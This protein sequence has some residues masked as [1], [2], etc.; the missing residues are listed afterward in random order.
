MFRLLRYFSIAS[1]VSLVLA[2]AVLGAVYRQIATRHLLE[3]GESNNVAL[4]QTLA[5]SFWPQLHSFADST[6][7]L[8]V[9]ALRRHPDIAGLRLGVV[10]Q[11]RDTNMIKVK[12]YNLD[13]RTLFSTETKQVGEY[14]SRNAGFLSARQGQPASEL[15]HRDQFSAFEQVIENRDVLSSYVALRRA[16]DAPIEGVVEVYSD[17]TDLLGGIER[18]QRLVTASVVVVLT[19]LYAILFFIVRHADRVIKGQYEQQRRSEHALRDA[20]EHLEHR[21]QERTT[22]LEVINH[23]L[24]IEVEERKRTEQRIEFMAYHDALTGLPNRELLLDRIK[25]SLTWA[26][27]RGV[28]LAV[29]FID[30]D[31]FK[32][33][34]DS[35]GHHIGDQVLQ[36]IAQRL[37]LCLREGDTIARVGGDEFIVSL[38]DI[39]SDLDLFQIAQKLLDAIVLPIEVA[40][41][42]LHLTAS[43]GIAMYPEHGRDVVTLMRNADSAMYSAK[44][45]GRNR[46]QMF[47]EHMNLRVQQRVMMESAMR[48]AIESNAFE[49]YYQPIVALDSGAIVGAEALLRWPNPHGAWISPVEFIPVAEESGLI[50]PLG[51]WV[52]NEACSQLHR[53]RERGLRDFTLA[54]NLSPCQFAS[55]G[56]AAKV[57][58]E[59]ERAE[60]DPAWLHLEITESL[61][62]SQSEVILANF[63][64]FERLGIKFSL[65]D[66]GTGY[67]SLGYL[68]RFPLHLLKIDRSFVQGL[69]DDSDNAAIVT[70]V[71]AM[72]KSLGMEV[73][74]EGIETDAQRMFLKRL[75]CSHGQGFLFS[76]P[77]PAD[78]FAALIFDPLEI[79]AAA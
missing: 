47:A 77:V 28:Q 42:T 23:S 69:P 45:L 20:Q 68:K 67:S 15:T 29:A 63:D 21:V 17:V 19:L 46:H 64:G 76:R 55:E 13:G 1:L 71:I 78:E 10:E 49:L 59:I 51:E 58:A 57:A 73:V 3:L 44:Q 65:D 60:I 35:L 53:W 5:N 66:F 40:G 54:V 52:L 48:H 37:P 41:H 12:L 25:Q 11:M 27:R 50:V 38:P 30:L 24:E 22:E 34:N 4:T 7:R 36:S 79:S 74:A 72:A 43:I 9:E 56:L 8:D 6:G 33:I 14:E 61:L 75:G 39:H 32:H 26:D 62:M 16:P 31:H 18:G 70:A 2:A